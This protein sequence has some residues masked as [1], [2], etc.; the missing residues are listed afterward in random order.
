M[1]MW[2][3]IPPLVAHLLYTRHVGPSSACASPHRLSHQMFHRT[4]LRMLQREY[5]DFRQSLGVVAAATADSPAVQSLAKKWPGQRREPIAAA[6]CMVLSVG[7]RCVLLFARI[8]A[9][10]R[11]ERVVPM[12]WHRAKIVMPVS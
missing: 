9:T 8:H 11:C 4:P 12:R 1:Q 3:Q 5:H 6:C 10:V 2:K 7:A